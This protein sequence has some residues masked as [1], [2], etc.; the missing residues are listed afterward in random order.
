MPICK[1]E[2]PALTT[3]SE[4]QSVICWLQYEQAPKIEK[5]EGI[6]GSIHGHA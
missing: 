6:K 3:V 2:R 4:S 5:P 1:K